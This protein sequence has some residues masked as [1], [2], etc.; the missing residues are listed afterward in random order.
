MYYLA[1]NWKHRWCF[2]YPVK[3]VS[4]SVQFTATLP[5]NDFLLKDNFGTISLTETDLRVL[6]YICERLEMMLVKISCVVL[7]QIITITLAN[8]YSICFHLSNIFN[9]RISFKATVASFSYIC[10]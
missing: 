8:L 6:C 1:L 2:T 4:R 7:S 10:F 5:N 3:T 9:A